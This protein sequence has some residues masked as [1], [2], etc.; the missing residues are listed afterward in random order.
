MKTSIVIEKD[1]DGFL[2]RVEGHENLFAFAYSEKDA[3]TELKNVVEMIM[4]Y[5][6]EQVNDERLIRNE[7]ATA[8]EK[9]AVQV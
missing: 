2:A 1:G 4:D 8:V 7:L 9:Y 6:L 3:V 5:H